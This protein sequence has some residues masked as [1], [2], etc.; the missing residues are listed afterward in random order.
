MVYVAKTKVL[1]SCAFAVQLSCPFVVENAKSRFSHYMGHSI[2]ENGHTT[3][4][5]SLPI[6]ISFFY[7]FLFD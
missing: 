3:V 2:M 6:K 7:L 1:I 4:C 5:R